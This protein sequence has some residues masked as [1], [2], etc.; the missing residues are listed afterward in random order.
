[1]NILIMML[2][3]FG[4]ILVCWIAALMVISE[5]DKNRLAVE[6]KN[7]RIEFLPNARSYWGV[8]VIIAVLCYPVVTGVISQIHSGSGAWLVSLCM[9]FIMLLLISFPGSIDVTSEGVE[10]NYWVGRRKRLAWR[11]VVGFEV[12]KKNKRVT[13]R[14]KSGPKIVHTRQ[15]P[16]RERLMAELEIHCSANQ[17]AGT[18]KKV[19]A[20]PVGKMENS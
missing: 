17:L 10:Q 11:D 6:S 13:I 3:I 4:S 8:Y 12:D 14:A 15:L 16:D 20:P 18:A 5:A 9:G 7:G 1:M 2:P 19:V